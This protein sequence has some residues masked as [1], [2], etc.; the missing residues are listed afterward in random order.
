MKVLL[1]RPCMAGGV[2]FGRGVWAGTMTKEMAAPMVSVLSAA[3]NLLWKP[4]QERR[5][6]AEAEEAGG[7]HVDDAPPLRRAV[8]RLR[9]DDEADPDHGAD[10]AVEDGACVQG[11]A[12][13]DGDERAGGTS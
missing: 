5:A 1:T 10:R 7:H 4:P 2:S 6:G 9:A 3:E 12:H 13:V 8:D 11:V